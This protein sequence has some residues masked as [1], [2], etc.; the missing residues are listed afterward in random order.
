MKQNLSG[1]PPEIYVL[2]EI[3]HIFIKLNDKISQG[4]RFQSDHCPCLVHISNFLPKG[5]ERLATKLG[6]VGPNFFHVNAPVRHR[7]NL[8][9]HLETSYGTF[10]ADH[11]M[12]SNI[13]W[14]SFRERFG[15]PFDLDSL[16]Q[17]SLDISFLTDPFLSGGNI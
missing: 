13:H 9:S 6:D 2:L 7:K 1:H 17:N 12:K 16:L 14:S 4:S 10:I 5:F 11:N 3:C 15:M 8:I